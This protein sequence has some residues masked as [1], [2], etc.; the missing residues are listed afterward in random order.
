MTAAS[1]IGARYPRKEDAALLTGGAR[2][3]DDLAPVAGIRHAAVL[4]SSHAH[5]RIAS[6]DVSKAAAFPG[7]RDVLTGTGIA[8]A[9]KPIPSAVRVPIAFY[10]IAV[11]KVRYVGEPVAVPRRGGGG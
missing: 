7:V 1:W 9:I 5:A 3:I 11:D 8:A 2:F 6:V 4:R 10:P